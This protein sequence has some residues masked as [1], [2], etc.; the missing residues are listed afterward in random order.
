[1]EAGFFT[2]PCPYFVTGKTDGWLNR[3]FGQVKN[4]PLVHYPESPLVLQLNRFSFLPWVDFSPRFGY[5][6]SVSNRG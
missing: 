6:E 3:R 5:L 2:K 1:L 4:Y